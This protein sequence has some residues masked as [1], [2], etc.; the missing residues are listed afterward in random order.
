MP[1]KMKFLPGYIFRKAKPAIVG[2]E[3]LAGQIKPKYFLMK[4]DGQDVG[5]IMQIQDKGEAAS[6][7]K[8]GSQVAVSLNQSVVGRHI[9]EK[10]IFYVKVPEEHVRTLLTKFQDRLSPQELE[11]L[12]ELVEMMRW[13]WVTMRWEWVT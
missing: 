2:I 10:D 12:S 13:E 9:F 11:T 6:E 4:K 8:A 1:G 3:V 5:E 7:A